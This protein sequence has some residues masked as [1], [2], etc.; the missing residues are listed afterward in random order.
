MGRICV[1]DMEPMAGNGG[2]QAVAAGLPE[3]ASEG[4]HLGDDSALRRDT[5]QF[6]GMKW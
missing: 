6:E 4:R 2:Y 1:L 5:E 3:G